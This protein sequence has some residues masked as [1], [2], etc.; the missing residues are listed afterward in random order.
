VQQASCPRD[1]P[2]ADAKG[3]ALIDRVREDR[4]KN[5]IAEAE[6]LIRTQRVKRQR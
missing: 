2:C 5:G 6:H 1:K 3:P 4:L